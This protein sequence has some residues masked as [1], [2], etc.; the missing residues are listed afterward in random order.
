M[1]YLSVQCPHCGKEAARLRF[2]ESDL[3]N[4]GHMRAATAELQV[5]PDEVLSKSAREAVLSWP[6]RSPQDRKLLQTRAVNILEL[7][8]IRTIGELIS[9]SEREMLRFNNCGKHTVVELREMLHSMNLSF[10][11][12]QQED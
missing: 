3:P 7:G 10:A 2:G 5:P 11:G 12:G 4:N 6:F 8:N 9:K 1:T